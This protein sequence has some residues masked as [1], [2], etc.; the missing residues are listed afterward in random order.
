MPT[1]LGPPAPG[2]GPIW[3]NFV[4][5]HAPP[6]SSRGR[7]VTLASAAAALAARLSAALGIMRCDDGPYAHNRT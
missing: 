3:A 5:H 4:S 6:G 7:S 1:P 2:P